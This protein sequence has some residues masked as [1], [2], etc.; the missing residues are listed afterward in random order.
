MKRQAKNA[1]KKQM[2]ADSPFVVGDTVEVIRGKHKG[3]FG[4]VAKVEAYYDY[5][6]YNYR[7]E[8]Y[9]GFT[10]D[11]GT[12]LSQIFRGGSIREVTITE[13]DV[14]GAKAGLMTTL[15]ELLSV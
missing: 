12:G 8:V 11:L 7:E 10:I 3:S 5:D 4:N 13:A 2:L 14:D 9:L 15:K 6:Y 1:D